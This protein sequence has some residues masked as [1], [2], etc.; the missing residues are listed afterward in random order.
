MPSRLI[1]LAQNG[2][3]NIGTNPPGGQNSLVP[4]PVRLSTTGQPSATLY[5]TIQFSTIIENSGSER[6]IGAGAVG[7]A[8]VRM[9]DAASGQVIDPIPDIASGQRLVLAIA[10]T[11]ATGKVTGL[12]AADTALPYRRRAVAQGWASYAS[13]EA[14][15]RVAS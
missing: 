8:P 13:D 14:V 4:V 12:E 9:I 5:L 11:D 10:V 2:Q 1:A 7:P 3:G 6:Q 15:W